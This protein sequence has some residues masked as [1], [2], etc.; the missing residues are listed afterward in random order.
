MNPRDKNPGLSGWLALFAAILVALLL[1][2][3][4]ALIDSAFN[5]SNTLYPPEYKAYRIET[6]HNV[7]FVATVLRLLLVLS[8][9][10]VVWLLHRRDRRLPHTF[11]IYGVC[12]AL[13]EVA[14][15]TVYF[16]LGGFMD[17]GNVVVYWVMTALR[18][19]LVVL[20]YV[21]LVRWAK[22]PQPAP[23]VVGEG[24]SPRASAH[25]KIG[26]DPLARRVAFWAGGALVAWP[27]VVDLFADPN[28]VIAAILVPTAVTEGYNMAFAI[29]VVSVVA[30]LLELMRLAFQMRVRWILVLFPISC[31][32]LYVV[33]FFMGMLHIT[34]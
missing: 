32:A 15:R 13:F 22:A 12:F 27:F 23:A 30:G 25:A 24:G 16:F 19:G 9:A 33:Y 31:G 3:G 20:G 26:S 8:G 5:M 1:L 29:Q 18:V 11:A 7:A 34:F 17:E 28:F 6:I 21:S 2:N 4:Q 10:Y 14:I